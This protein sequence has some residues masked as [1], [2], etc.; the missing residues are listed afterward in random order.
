MTIHSSPLPKLHSGAKNKK[1]KKKSKI[2]G[3]T[4]ISSTHG[5]LTIAVM[6]PGTVALLHQ[7]VK[8]LAQQ[9]NTMH[10]MA[11]TQTTKEAVMTVPV[12][13]SGIFPTTMIILKSTTS[14]LMLLRSGYLTTPVFN[15]S[16]NVCLLMILP[17]FVNTSAWMVL[18]S[19][20][21]EKSR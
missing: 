21:L 14:L 8:R 13:P 15:L 9:K 3:R 4:L 5:I 7:V 20:S 12:P 11:M 16:A 1:T 18:L 6:T 17:D 10:Q 19:N 2:H